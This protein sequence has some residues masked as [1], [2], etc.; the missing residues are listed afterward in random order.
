MGTSNI[1]KESMKEWGEQFSLKNQLNYN[2]TPKLCKNCETLIP[3]E[4][5]NA[6]KFCS[7]SCS[8]T[9]SNIRRRLRPK[10]NCLFCTKELVGRNTMKYCSSKCQKCFEREST[11]QDW[12]VNG[13]SPGWRYIKSILFEDRGEICEICGISEWNGKSLSL[14]VDHIDGIH[15]NNSPD[16]LRIICPNCHSQTD[17]YKAKNKGNGRNC[18]RINSTIKFN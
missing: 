1:H 6:N 8:A 2:K 15:T 9:Y 14:E 12:Y 7:S 10:R 18:R 3:Y 17:T 13:N 11:R 5:R 16:N 4:K